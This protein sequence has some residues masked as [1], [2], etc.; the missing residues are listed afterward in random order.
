VGKVS[1]LNQRL[2]AA[3]PQPLRFILDAIDRLGRLDGWLGALCLVSLTL[4][5]LAE[6]AVRFF[7][8]FFSWVPA[9]IPVAWEYGSYL[10]AA[11]FTFG[12]AMTLRAGGHIRVTLLTGNVSPPVRRWLE[13]AC[14]LIATA[15]VGFLAYAMIKFTLGSYERGQTSISSNTPI[16]IPQAV[17]S[18]GMLL[19]SLQALARF[20][21]ACLG[22]ALE[23]PD[24]KPSSGME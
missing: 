7:S 22:L 21:Q 13:I 17:V 9:H 4:L 6:V 1:D 12:A 14:A 11:T 2:N 23:N 24:F 10:M 15:F 8:R 16:W 19:L 18:F 20:I 3:A 5:I